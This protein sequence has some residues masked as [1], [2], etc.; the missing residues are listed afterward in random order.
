LSLRKGE[1]RLRLLNFQ[2]NSISAIDHLHSLPNLI[3]LDL[4]NNEL[5]AIQNLAVLSSLRVLMLGKNRITQI[6]NLECLR[7]L[8][9]GHHTWHIQHASC[10]NAA[11][12]NA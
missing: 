4:Y 1:E 7:K 3:F 10:F 12:L 2:N 6:A 8:E 9:V 5:T 11:L